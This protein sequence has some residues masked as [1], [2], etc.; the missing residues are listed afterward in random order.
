MVLPHS[1]LLTVF[2]SMVI[3]WP[4]H[5][6]ESKCANSCPTIA[7]ILSYCYDFYLPQSRQFILSSVSIFLPH[8]YFLH[9]FI[10]RKERWSFKKT[11]P[12]F[13]RFMT[14][15]ASPQRGSVLYPYLSLFVYR[16]KYTICIRKG[17][18]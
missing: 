5:V 2:S 10:L 4:C 18:K 14:E 16:R 9:L 3:L 17:S 6:L 12:Y 11:M 8:I 7:K 15:Q 1:T 13:V